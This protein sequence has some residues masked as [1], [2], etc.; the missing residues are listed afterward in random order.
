MTF[1][2]EI[3]MVA[4]EMRG[5]ANEGARYAGAIRAHSDEPGPVGALPIKPGTDGETWAHVSASGRD[6]R[7][8]T[9][10]IARRVR[11]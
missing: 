1:Q 3:Y 2:D 9:Q 6:G 7:V 11:L 5:I 8:G 10:K 4:G